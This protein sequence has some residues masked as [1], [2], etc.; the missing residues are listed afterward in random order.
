MKIPL[1]Q[2]EQ[3]INETI[4]KRGFSYFKNGYVSELLEVSTGEYEALVI[5]TDE[6]TVQLEVK[7]NTIV[8]HNCDCPYD[9]GPVCKHIVAV[10]FHLQQD[11]LDLNQ[12][13]AS[14]TKKKKTKPI[15]LQVKGIL[16]TISH[17]E[18]MEF[19][20]ENSKN[21]R[22]FRNYFLASF[23]HLSENQSKEFYQKQINSILKTAA[24]RDGFIYWSD[25]KYVV[26]AIDPFLANSEKY[27][28]KNSFENVIHISTA[29]L[30][31]MTEALQYGDDSNGD[32]GDF[33]S[34]SMEM[35]AEIA[36]RKPPENIKKELFEY[37]LAVFNQGLFSGWDWHLGMIHIAYEL[38]ETEKE[39]DTI[40][41]CLDSVY[42]KYEQEQAQS[43]KLDIIKKYK[44]EEEALKFIEQ[45]ISNSLIRRDE[46]ANALER[47]NFERAIKLSKDG[48]ENDKK[49]KPGLAIEWYDWLLKIAQARNETPEIIKYARFLLIDN[50]RAEQDYYQILKS[51]VDENQWKSFVEEIIGEITPQT[52]WTS[53]ELIRSIYIKEEWWGRLF[54]LL[55]QNVS[56]D[57]IENNEKYLAKDYAPQLVQL[58]SERITDYVKINIGR[59][60]YQTACR[61]LRRMKKLGGREQ[62]DVLI[63]HFR[64]AYPQRRALMSELNNV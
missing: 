27:L 38:I 37:C 4:L 7:N 17:E 9:M 30:E 19:V 47:K 59:N 16:K 21:D 1:E 58:Y 32:L 63:E 28:E 48:I 60:H 31:E 56:L 13:E 5:G 62:A 46:I 40:I 61:Y 49:D 54:A 53:T 11:L 10:I 29:L 55:K 41:N 39:A 8:G 43:I 18:L 15:S 6:Y 2:F 25:M 50:F 22:K 51:K 20:Q 34:A 44:D 33:I 12:S 45:H 3:I 14:K 23:G 52:R 64:E 24:G 42:N 35:L 36:S 26:S 57:T